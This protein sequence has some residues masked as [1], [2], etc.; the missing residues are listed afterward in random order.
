M[1]RQIV[2]IIILLSGYASSPALAVGKGPAYRFLKEPAVKWDVSRLTGEV[3]NAPVINLITEILQKEGS[4]WQVIGKLT[5]T[6]S[7]SFDHLTINDSI[8][9]IMRIS[10]YNYALVF[11]EQEPADSISSHLIKELTIYQGDRRIR[12][13]RTATQPPA[14]GKKIFKKTPKPVSGRITAASPAKPTAQKPKI[15]NTRQS[16]PTREE[17]AEFDR[18]MK[19]AADELLAEKKITL[20]EYKELIGELEVEK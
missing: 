13:S 12:F 6:I 17:I 7:I 3:K 10:R 9:K 1:I 16:E 15:P 8:K 11:E 20:K 2:L 4:N 5:G 19:A 18:E 14:P